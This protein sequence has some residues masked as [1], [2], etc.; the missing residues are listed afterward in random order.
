MIFFNVPEARDQLMEKGIVYT[1]RSSTRAV[2]R[3]R[4][5]TGGYYEHSLLC[6]VDVQKVGPISHPDDLYPYVDQSGFK[7]VD[8]WMSKATTSARTLYRVTKLEEGVQ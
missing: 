1:L 3:T 4:A 6:L 7:N 2:G 5:V 8:I